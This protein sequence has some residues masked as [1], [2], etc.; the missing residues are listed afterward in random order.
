MKTIL[1]ILSGLFMI[2]SL[3]IYSA[4]KPKT[5]GNIP[6]EVASLKEIH[7]LLGNQKVIF[8]DFYKD[9]C[10][11][12][13]QFK[14]LYES[15]ARLFGKQIIFIKINASN[16]KTAALCD[17]FQISSLPTLIVLDNQGEEV[18]KHTGMEE[19]K[20]MNIKRF[21]AYVETQDFK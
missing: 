13:K 2:C 21:L 3:P 16:P 15:W 20:K 6:L 5:Q 10:P 1:V 9:S 14:P 11:P 19:I 12:C 4:N 7:A 8:I 18:A 17:K